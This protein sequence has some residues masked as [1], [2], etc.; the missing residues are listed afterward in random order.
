VLLVVVRLDR[1]VLAVPD[2]GPRLKVRAPERSSTARPIGAG[3]W[4]G[5]S[6][7][8]WWAW[9]ANGGGGGGGAD[10]GQPAGRRRAIGIVVLT[11]DDIVVRAAMWFGPL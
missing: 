7:G 10:A 9:H 2:L 8:Y 4:H 5:E 6:H 1:R 3:G 11:W